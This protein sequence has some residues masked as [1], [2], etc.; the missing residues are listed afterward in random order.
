MYWIVLLAGVGLW[1]AA[2]VFKRVAPARRAAIGDTGKG[3]MAAAIGLGIVLMVIGYRGTDIVPVWNPPSFLIHINNLAMLIALFLLSPAPKKGKL[4]SGMRHPMLVGFGVWA[5][6]H[7]LVNGDLASFLMFGGLLV[8]AVASARMINA[9]EPNWAP[10][11]VGTYAK[12]AMFAVASFIL[13]V[14][15]GYIHSWLGVWP[16]PA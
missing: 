13:L 4:A 7:L 16:F 10:N 11:P 5:G 9:A 15:V 2:H 8:W 3:M 6:A 14:I 12:D 1:W